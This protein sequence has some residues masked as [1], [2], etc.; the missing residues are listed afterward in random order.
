MR[1]RRTFE[2]DPIVTWPPPTV[3]HEV[4][5]ETVDV[6]HVTHEN[7]T[8][9]GEG[10]TT[11]VYLFEDSQENTAFCWFLVEVNVIGE[12]SIYTDIKQQRNRVW[13]QSAAMFLYFIQNF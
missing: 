6:V 5:N 2:P 13:S 3:V 9:F 11:I 4:V 8:T 1:E 7:G 10:V 12:R